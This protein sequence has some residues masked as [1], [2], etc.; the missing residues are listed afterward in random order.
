MHQIPDSDD[1]NSAMHASNVFHEILDQ[2]QS[3][4]LNFQLQVSP[5]SA[6][7]SLKKSLVRNK[8]GNMLPPVSQRHDDMKKLMEKNNKLQNVL[9][10]LQSKHEVVVNNFTEACQTIETLQN[11][12][13]EEI[14]PIVIHSDN[15]SI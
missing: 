5:F 1:K 6:Q 10:I 11:K 7:I 8:T 15:K 14:K 4:N 12:I 9:S 13:K 2:I 3:S